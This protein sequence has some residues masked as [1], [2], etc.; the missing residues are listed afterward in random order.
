MKPIF[1]AEIKTQSPF[2]YKSNDSFATLMECAIHHGDWVAVHTNALW[3]GDFDAISFVRKY[4]DKPILAKGIHGTNDDIHRAF[5]HGANYV[6]VVDRIPNTSDYLLQEKFKA[7][8]LMEFSNISRVVG[9]VRFN[10]YWKDSKYVYNARDLQTGLPRR[11][12]QLSTLLELGVWTCQASM[13]TSWYDVNPN[14]QAFI[15]G[16]HLVSFCNKL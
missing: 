13:I 4:T 14:V 16:E 1:I 12:N 7:R 8:V 5:D 2:G 3:G 6:L 15:V 9:N 10:Q 11:T